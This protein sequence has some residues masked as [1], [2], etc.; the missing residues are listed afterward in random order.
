MPPVRRAAMPAA[1]SVPRCRPTTNSSTSRA[2]SA[3][4]STAC[5]APISAPAI[6]NDEIADR[7]RK[8]G[9]VFEVVDDEAVIGRTVDA[10]VAEKA[11]GWFQGRMEFGPRAL[12]ARSIL[13]DPRSP[14]MQKQLNLKIKFRESFRPFAPSVLREDIAEW[15]DLDRDSP[16]ML[17]VAQVAAKRQNDCVIPSARAR[18][19]MTASYKGCKRFDR[20]RALQARETSSC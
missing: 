1:R 20:L 17:V 9:A 2:G 13:G 12:G 11:V 15:F 10:L 18:T 19:S 6:N 5:R 14:R 3:I 4:S 8:A 16:Y 7:L